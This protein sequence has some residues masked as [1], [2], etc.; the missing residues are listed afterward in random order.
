MKGRV[1]II[2]G[3]LA[4]LMVVGCVMW[5]APEQKSAQADTAHIASPVAQRVNAG[6]MPYRG[7]VLQVQRIDG[8]GMEYKRAID[9]IADVGA[10]SVEIVVDSRQENGSSSMIF[11]DLRMTPSPERLTDL[12]K[13]AKSRKLRVLVMPIVLLE[14]PVGNEWRGTIKPQIWE[15]W[16]N[17]YRDMILHYA[18]VAEAGGADVFMV[19][20]ELVSTERHIDEWR[21]TIH[22]IRQTFHGQVTYSANWDHYQ[23]IPFWE[24]LDLIGMNSYWKLGE[25][26]DVSVDEI[27]RRWHDIQ[28]D[29]F[30]FVH[31]THRPLIFT[32]V[33][34]C[35]L[36]N[37][38]HE[39]W[40]Y[41]K[42]EVPVDLELQRKLYE[43]F[44]RAWQGSPELGGFSFW[45]YTIG[46]GGPSDRGYTPIGKPA[47][48]VLHEWLAKP[49]WTVNP[50]S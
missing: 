33:G 15:E 5:P 16:F 43:G 21:H 34:W 6:G 30:A 13:Y 32:E 47:E 25:N 12:I 48:Q 19:G 36:A 35:S 2:L 29:L 18:K 39:P 27:V 23:S 20:S 9:A 41:T 14:K 3:L 40:D 26:K 28:R 8:E 11:L 44:F 46:Q 37:A 24:Q 10:D 22:D 17:S 42:Q 49:R 4:Y 31:K 38:A 45:Q 50:N 7:M 1:W